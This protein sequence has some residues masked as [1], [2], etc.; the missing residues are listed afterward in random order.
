[1]AFDP[2][3]Q[4][5]QDRPAIRCYPA[6]SQVTGRRRRNHQILDQERFMTLESRSWRN[7]D[8]DH[9]FF[10]FDDPRRDLASAGWLP[11]LLGRRGGFFH[12]ARF[13]VRAP[14]QTLQPGVSSRNSATFCFREA[15][16]HTV[17]PAALQARHGP[18]R[19]AWRAAAHDVERRRRRIGARKGAKVAPFTSCASRD[20]STTPISESSDVFLINWTRN[21]TVGGIAMVNVRGRITWRNCRQRVRPSAADASR[22]PSGIASTAPRQMSARN[23]LP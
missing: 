11:L 22:W 23:A 3:W 18:A 9:L 4:C 16:H 12:A 7:L 5:G 13:D 17:R 6:F 20:S 14:F 1:M 2:L 10:D 19:K 15:T 21:P 8:P